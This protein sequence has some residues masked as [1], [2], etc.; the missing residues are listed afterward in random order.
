[1]NSYQRRLGLIFGATA[2]II[3]LVSSSSVQQTV[4]FAQ[5]AYAVSEKTKGCG[6]FAIPLPSDL[7]NASLSIFKSSAGQNYTIHRFKIG[8]FS[9]N[10]STVTAK[11]V[12]VWVTF[13]QKIPN[14]DINSSGVGTLAGYYYKTQDWDGSFGYLSLHRTP[15]SVTI[16]LQN[17]KLNFT[18]G[19]NEPQ[20]Q[21]HILNF[22]GSVDNF[23]FTFRCITQ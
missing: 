11:D 6:S 1:M 17:V 4:S 7:V 8:S 16:H 12:S 20:Y 15:T 22:Y 9:I 10:D 18:L 21:S 2:L 13:S 19:T 14:Y 3:L 5:V 23:D